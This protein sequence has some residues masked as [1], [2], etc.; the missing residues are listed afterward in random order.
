MNQAQPSTTTSEVASRSASGWKTAT[1]VFDTWNRAN[2]WERQTFS[3]ELRWGV[4]Y[5][6]SDPLG[7]DGILG[8]YHRDAAHHKGHNGDNHLTRS[9]Q[10]DNPYQYA[11]ENPFVFFDPNGLTPC[12]MEPTVP[13][14]KCH[15]YG[16]GC[17]AAYCSDQVRIAVCR[18]EHLA[19]GSAFFDGVQLAPIGFGIGFAWGAGTTGGLAAWPAGGVGAAGGFV[20]GFFLS[21]GGVKIGLEGAGNTW[22]ICMS[23]C[24]CGDPVIGSGFDLAS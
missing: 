20:V 18:L 15:E 12:S 24:T 9:Y 13:K 22:K 6:Q 16:S 19:L 11:F 14:D 3:T 23:T 4:R 17:C 21:D 5:S 1:G 7:A 10:K 2:L 8:S